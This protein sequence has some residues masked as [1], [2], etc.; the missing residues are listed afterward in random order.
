MRGVPVH[1]APLGSSGISI[2]HGT[3]FGTTAVKPSHLPSGDQRMSDGVSL[4]VVICDV[5]PSASIHLT[6]IC[7]PDGL[8]SVT[9]AMRVPS[10]DQMAPPPLARK[11]FFEPSMLMIQSDDSNLSSSLLT[12]RR[13]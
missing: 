2:F 13:A 5:A 12:Q 10:G 7:V 9:N 11:R 8:P 6:W 1:F 4:S 3:T